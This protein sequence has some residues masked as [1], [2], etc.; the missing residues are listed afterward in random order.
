MKVN[1]KTAKTNINGHSELKRNEH[2]AHQHMIPSWKKGP[3]A[4][5]K[6]LG[7][8]PPHPVTVP[9]IQDAHLHC[10]S[11]TSN[12]GHRIIVMWT[13]CEMEKPH[14]S[15]KVCMACEQMSFGSEMTDQNLR[16]DA[17]SYLVRGT[18]VLLMVMIIRNL[19]TSGTLSTM[20]RVRSSSV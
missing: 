19:R 3:S 7:R 15:G 12:K 18:T 6:L 5:E 8:A 9:Y 13:S 20:A 1:L 2:D 10:P 16:P 17:V 14:L 4:T 11:T